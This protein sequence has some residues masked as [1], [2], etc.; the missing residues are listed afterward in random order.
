[1]TVYM[2]IQTSDKSDI[3]FRNFS[4]E[5]SEICSS[6]NETPKP[7]NDKKRRLVIR[8][9]WSKTPCSMD[10]SV[11]HMSAILPKAIKRIK[12]I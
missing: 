11:S 3:T 7:W 1:M 2:N 4:N 8:P 5:M 12:Q 6:K 9:D 10:T